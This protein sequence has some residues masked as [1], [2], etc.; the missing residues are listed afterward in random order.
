MVQ[1]FILSTY[2]KSLAWKKD[3]TVTKVVLDTG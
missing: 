3:Y 2:C 1:C